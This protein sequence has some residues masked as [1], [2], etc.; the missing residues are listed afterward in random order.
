M[1]G[2]SRFLQ[3]NFTTSSIYS[4]T[5]LQRWPST[6]RCGRSTS[7]FARIS[8]HQTVVGLLRSRELIVGHEY[9]EDDDDDYLLTLAFTCRP[10]CPQQ[11]F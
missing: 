2:G 4:G 3:A 1:I 5:M 11:Q 8:P 10:F 9:S 7:S 6:F